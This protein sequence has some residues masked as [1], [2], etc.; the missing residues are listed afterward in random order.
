MDSAPPPLPGSMSPPTS[1][2]PGRAGHHRG[3]SAPTMQ[4]AKRSSSRITDGATSRLSDDDAKTAVKVAVR[5]RPPL[6][7]SDP[8]FDLIPQRFRESTCEVPTP[9]S[10]SVQSPQGKKLFVFD[11]VFDESTSQEPIWDYLSDSVA[12]FIKGYNV[13]ILAYGQS[14]SGKSYTMGTSGPE[15]QHDPNVMGIIPRAAR[16]LFESLNG[17]T[18]RHTG[19]QTPKRYST[20]ALPTLGSLAKNGAASKNWELKA[21]YVEIYNE[22]L[23]DLLVPEHVAQADRPQ[24]AIREDTKGRILLTGLYQVAINSVDDLLS[25]LNFG[26]SIR[27]T[28]ATAINARSSRSHAVFS[29]NL[30]Q[31]RNDRPGSP[32]S[33]E[34]RMS[35]PIDALSGAENVVTIDSKLHFVDLAGSERLKNTGATGDRAKEGI[36]IN[37]GLASLGKVIS[38]LSSRHG[39]GHISYRD[40]RL[41]RLLQDSLGGNAITFMVACVTPAVFHL[42]ETLNTVHYAQRA[43]AIQSKPEIQQSHEDGD[44][45]AAI[46]RLRAEVAFL[47]DQ[48]RHSEH[49]DRRGLGENGRTDRLKGR[50]A[51]LHTQLMDMQESYNALSQ[52]HGKLISELSKAR[53]SDTADTP[54]LREAIGENALER[55]KRSSSF[56]QAVEQMVMEYEKTIQSLE[57]S[58]SKTRSTLSSSESTLMEK[59]TRIAYMETIQQ[60]LQARVHKAMDREQSNESYLRDL[61]T[62]MEGSTSGEEKNASLIAELRKE[63]TRVRE[64]EDSAEDYISTL[65]ERLAEA[66]Q[67]QEIMQR[68]ID[69]LEHVIERQR[70]IGRLDNL[71]VELDGIRQNEPGVPA[72]PVQPVQ[73]SAPATNGFHQRESYDPFRP[74]STAEEADDFKDAQSEQPMPDEPTGLYEDERSLADEPNGLH[75]PDHERERSSSGKT[76]RA[77]AFTTEVRSPA[78]TDFMADKVEN[79][80]QE[81]CDL[82]FEHESNITDYDKLQQKYQT[83]LETLAKLEYGKETPKRPETPTPSRPTSFLAD[84]GMRG[85]EKVG[86]RGQPSSSRSLSAELSSHGQSRSTGAEEERGQY[87]SD[88][89]RIGMLDETPVPDDVDP[90]QVPLPA[91]ETDVHKEMELLRRLHAE[92][93]VSVSELTNNYKSLA[94]RHELT[95][96]Q[97]EDL[98]QELQKA[99]NAFRPASPSFNKPVFRRKSDDILHANNDRASRSFASLKNISL[100]RFESDPDTR[101][102]FELNLSTIMTEL[103]GRTERAYSLEAELG[104]V[105]K[106]L[107]GKQTIIAGLTR[108]R[109]TLAAS[110]GVDYTVVGQMRDQLVESEHQIRS[111]HEQNAEMEKE[112]QSQIETLRTSLAEHQNAAAVHANQ[113]PTPSDDH[114][115]HMPGDFPETPALESAFTRELGAGQTSAGAARGVKGGEQADD[116]ARLQ[117]ELA[118]WEAKHQDAMESMKASEAKLLN[119]ITDLEQSMSKAERGAGSH[120]RTA[121]GAEATAAAASFEEERATH[122]QVVETLQKEVDQYKSTSSNHVTKLEQLE[123]SY[124]KILRQV[125]DDSKSRDLSQKELR[126]HKD[127]VSNL[128]NQLQVHKSAITM[129]QE[130]LESLQASHSRE[131]GDLKTSMEGAEKES[132]ERH[133]ALEEHHNLVVQNMEADLTSAQGQVSGLLRSASSALGYETD[134]TQLHSQIKGLVEEGKELHTRHLKTTNELKLV[135]EELQNALNNTVVLENQIGEL[136]M[137]NEEALLNLKK[138]SEKEKKSARLVEELEE[139]LNSNFDS[140]QQANHRLS[141]MQSETVQA[142]MEIERDLEDQKLRNNLLEQQIAGLKRLSVTSNSSAINFNRESL[143]PE[144]AAIALARSG[145]QTSTRKSGTPAV[146][147]TPPPSI[148]LPPLPGTPGS[149]QI[150]AMPPMERATSPIQRTASPVTSASPPGSRHTSKDVGPSMSQLVEEQEARIRTI[151]KHLFAEKQLTATLEEALVDLETSANRTK[152]EM[153][154]W[155]KK[156]TTL[157]DEM[158][159]LRKD[160]TNSRVSLQAVEEEREMRLRA[161]RARQALE[162]RMMELNATKKK[163]KSALNC[164]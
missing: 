135:Q 151:E 56:A 48:I 129:H 147:P 29:L 32:P 10:L 72:P 101:Q 41:T 133:A 34:K 152:S 123:Q 110:S 84:A 108:E 78:Q 125:D 157:E 46:D 91:D 115:S 52:R 131:M 88:S 87:G 111:L 77:P 39:N 18:A 118:A 25:A 16:A 159:G 85:E 139:Q 57:S 97:V 42:S 100:D 156:C 24:V 149:S 35:M 116:I 60:Q 14:G 99:Y 51:E 164:F 50:E 140:H 31:K 141:T 49:S 38:Q 20:Q 150:T 19:M 153:D 161:E 59:E 104:T 65:E 102:N 58:L 81:L 71:L 82:R 158:V 95:L 121:P 75:T 13:S 90:A 143:S 7:P 68:E 94:Q 127:L 47:R 54:L 154:S 155:R 142:R 30:V 2:Q 64:T 160:R 92:K 36:S 63:L 134:P 26:S 96:A 124:A 62:Q 61:E 148:P 12:S 145:S 15:D 8:G 17:T 27:Q 9:T 80:T 162:Q 37:A 138:V 83:A 6:N 106:E 67:D 132:R 122:R 53:E 3:P 66:E 98:K 55:I 146:L 45:Q 4:R 126:T 69:R 136:K 105:R 107:E 23:R 70:S 117:S 89:D 112:F 28:D 40:S 43:R 86:M 11:R 22:Q 21:S 5:V 73:A 79:L 119:T 144:A 137:L 114:F 109:S 163:K 113:L 103:H 33:A 74:N 44:K 76:M 93:E 130:T 120:E 1:P 128:E